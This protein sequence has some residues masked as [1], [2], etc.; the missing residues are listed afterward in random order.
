VWGVPGEPLP[1]K[2]FFPSINVG[3]NHDLH[4]AIELHLWLPP[5]FFSGLAVVSLKIVDVQGSDEAFI[6]ANM[7]FSA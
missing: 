2:P 1:V 4:K 3:L 6:H 5:K 7:F